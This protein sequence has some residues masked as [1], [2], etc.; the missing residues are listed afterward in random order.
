M[1]VLSLNI[2]GIGGTL[3]TASFRRL[4]ARTKP[5]LILLQETLSTDYLARDFIHRFR[6]SWFSAAVS[7]IGTSGGLLVA[8]DPSLYTLT[9]VLSCGGLLLRGICLAT[10]VEFALLNIYGPCSGKSSFWSQLEDSGLLSLNNLIIGGD[11]NLFF[12]IEESWGD[13]HLPE[14]S[15]LRFKEIFSNHS[16]LDIRPTILSP[17]WRNGR[18]GPNAIARRLDRFFV[19]ASLLTSFGQA[20]SWVVFPYIS[21][22][23]PVILQLN[24]TVLP[25]PYPFKFNHSWLSRDDYVEL[26][27]ETWTDPL[28]N[29]DLNPQTRLVRKLKALKHKTKHWFHLKQL[30]EQGRMHTLESEISNL[31]HRFNNTPMRVEDSDCLKRLEADR[32]ALLRTEEFAWRL[33]SRATWLKCG[34]SNTK[35]FHRVASHNRH[36]KLIWSI[37][38]GGSEIRGQ[39]DIK[40]EAVSHFSQQFKATGALNLQDKG[41]TAG[42]YSRLVSGDEAE[43]LYNPVTIAEIKD[44][45]FISILSEAQARTAGLQNSSA[46][47]LI[48]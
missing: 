48:W 39:V 41:T 43:V 25:S 33:R 18:S 44:I 36:K 45:L 19:S 1:I 4:L 16:L 11:L 7:S 12:E 3:K 9:P 6:P 20:S 10:T 37:E 21:D 32:D 42:L 26:V 46:S 35:Y 28:L 8:W 14:P 27:R 5:D 13:V 34:D 47:F 29:S 40:K 23:A 30:E 15:G 24:L 31:T 22:H 38:K 2:R 17:T